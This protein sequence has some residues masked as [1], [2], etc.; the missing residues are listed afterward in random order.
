M[1]TAAIATPQPPPIHSG[2]G[3]SLW[4]AIRE[5]R[6]FVTICSVAPIHLTATKPHMR[7]LSVEEKAERSA[8]LAPGQTVPEFAQRTLYEIPAVEKGSY[9]TLRVYDTAQLCQIINPQDEAVQAPAPVPCGVVAG[10]LIFDW[11]EA[12]LS[13]AA[14]E[15]GKCALGVGI[16]AGDEPA[17]QEVERLMSQQ[18]LYFTALVRSA[19][20]HWLNGAYL[21]IAGIHRTAAKW[22]ELPRDKHEW[23]GVIPQAQQQQRVGCL[24]CGEMIVK[25]AVKCRY[26]A[27][28]L[29]AYCIE[30]DI[31]AEE[32]RSAD[33]LLADKVANK[34]KSIANKPKS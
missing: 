12:G 25:G 34:R 23:M 31:K 2:G 26:C 5:S 11:A 3:W 1:S 4:P 15:G 32:I 19:D 13:V 30:N 24:L 14:E 9:R 8:L 18:A 27:T 22:L 20:Q 17:E 7:P 33:P 28:D 29:L 6:S 16:I 21:N 10:A